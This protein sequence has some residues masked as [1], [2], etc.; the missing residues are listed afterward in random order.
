MS[1]PP[2]LPLVC[3]PCRPGADNRRPSFPEAHGQPCHVPVSLSPRRRGQQTTHARQRHWG[4]PL[5]TGSGVSCVNRAG[6]RLASLAHVPE[7]SSDCASANETLLY[8]LCSTAATGAVGY[9]HACYPLLDCLVCPIERALMFVLHGSIRC[10]HQ[11]G[12]HLWSPL[13]IFSP[14]TSTFRREERSS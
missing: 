1:I 9:E 10:C 7:L 4:S 12:A 2:P 14:I 5:R 13:I 11:Q 6:R 8:I 3:H